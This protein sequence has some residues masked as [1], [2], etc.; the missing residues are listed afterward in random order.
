[1]IL[2][3]GRR[4]GGEGRRCLLGPPAAAFSSCNVS[5]VSAAYASALA[6][7]ATV[8]GNSLYPGCPGDPTVGISTTP[9]HTIGLLFRFLFSVSLLR[10]NFS[11]SGNFHSVQCHHAPPTYHTLPI[12]SHYVK[13]PYRN[14]FGSLPPPLSGSLSPS[15][16][17]SLLYSLLREDTYHCINIVISIFLLLLVT[18]T[19]YS[20]PVTDTDTLRESILSFY[21]PW[22]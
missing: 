11:L 21:G 19:C 8:Y 22:I 1:M 7:P 18:V 12:R 4:A 10:Y 15:Y 2:L 6:C 9:F 5:P 20:I 13:K 3:A 16:S 14:N 17:L